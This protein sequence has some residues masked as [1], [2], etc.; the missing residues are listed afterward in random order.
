MKS[1]AWICVCTV[2]GNFE[3]VLFIFDP[4]NPGSTEIFMIFF[5]YY[6]FYMAV[7]KAVPIQ[8]RYVTLQLKAF[9][10]LRTTDIFNDY[11]NMLLVLAM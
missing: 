8:G 10:F 4:R 5:Y 3:F 1:P 6:Y 11:T 9:H 2:C 7:P